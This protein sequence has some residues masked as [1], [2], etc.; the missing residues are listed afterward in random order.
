MEHQNFLTLWKIKCHAEAGVDLMHNTAIYW[1][2]NLYI[3]CVYTE[4]RYL[5]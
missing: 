1:N 3:L 4:F 5:L 2:K